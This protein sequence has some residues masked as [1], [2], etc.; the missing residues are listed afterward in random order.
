LRSIRFAFTK[1]FGLPIFKRSRLFPSFLNQRTLNIFRM[2]LY[3]GGHTVIH[4]SVILPVQSGMLSFVSV[5]VI[6]CV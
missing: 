1:A 5:A 2:S 4:F 3:P 6:L